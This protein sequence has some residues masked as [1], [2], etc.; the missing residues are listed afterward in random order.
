MFLSTPGVLGMAFI[1]HP[2][3]CMGKEDWPPSI[4]QWL[5]R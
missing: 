2:L 3:W 4:P 5:D 1:G